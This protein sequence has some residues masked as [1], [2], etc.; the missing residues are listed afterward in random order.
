MRAPL[1]RTWFRLSLGV[2]AAW[3]SLAAAAAPQPV[4]STDGDFDQVVKPFLAEHCNR[5]HG[6]EKQKGE[7]RVDTLARD[8]GAGSASV[9][10][11]D[12]I[13]RI[14]NGEMPPKKEPRPSAAESARV[15]EWL[16]ARLEEG[17]A[18]SRRC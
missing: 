16:A 15:V 3:F 13:D 2:V 17:K 4:H 1:T 6:E 12:V 10:W 14:S 5:C 7:F 11:G 18:A 9:R 8:F